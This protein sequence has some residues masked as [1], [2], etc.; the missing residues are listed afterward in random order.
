MKSKRIIIRCVVLLWFSL[1]FIVYYVTF[2]DRFDFVFPR[3]M[4]RVVELIKVVNTYFQ[5]VF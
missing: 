3:Q 1:V 2:F 4:S 5:K